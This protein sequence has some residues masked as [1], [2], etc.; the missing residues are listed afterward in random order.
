MKLALQWVKEMLPSVRILNCRVKCA[1]YE[2]EL[3][4]KNIYYGTIVACL[5]ERR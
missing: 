1:C 3:D 4:V 2:L 5:L